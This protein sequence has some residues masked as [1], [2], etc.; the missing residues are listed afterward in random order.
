MKYLFLKSTT[1]SNQQPPTTN[2]QPCIQPHKEGQSHHMEKLMQAHQTSIHYYST[3][4]L[5][6]RKV[7]VPIIIAFHAF[8]I[9][10]LNQPLNS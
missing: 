5:R 6:S 3:F 2:H 8:Q 10:S 9:F 7:P 1:T 4:S